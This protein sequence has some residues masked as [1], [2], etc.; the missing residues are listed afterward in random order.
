MVHKSFKYFDFSN[1]EI[2]VILIIIGTV[3]QSKMIGNN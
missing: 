2:F 1:K 3:P